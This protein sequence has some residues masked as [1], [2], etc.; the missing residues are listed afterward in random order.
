MLALDAPRAPLFCSTPRNTREKRNERE[1]LMFLLLENSA[2]DTPAFHER[3]IFPTL[4]WVAVGSLSMQ[5]E[6]KPALLNIDSGIGQSCQVSPPWVRRCRVP[7][8]RC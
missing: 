5:L 3:N 1:C 7:F 4:Q 6:V 2:V 8:S